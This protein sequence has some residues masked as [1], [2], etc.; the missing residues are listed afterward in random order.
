M[1]ILV[2]VIASAF[3]LSGCE[4]LMD[5]GAVG[6]GA[7]AVGGADVAA[8]GFEGADGAAA[9][10]FEG[11]EGVAAAEAGETEI[12]V[13]HD[14]FEMARDH[15]VISRALQQVTRNGTRAGSMTMTRSG[16]LRA[17]GRAIGKIDP[18]TGDIVGPRGVPAGYISNSQIFEFV[19]NGQSQAVA[20]LRGF[21][22]RNGVRLSPR[23]G[24]GTEV[25]ILH[26]RV[27]LDVLK[28]EP[29][30]YLVRLQDGTVGYIPSEAAH[31]F[32]LGLAQY[33]QNCQR[34]RS[35]AIVERSG[36]TVPF[37]DCSVQDGRFVIETTDGP[38]M[39]DASDVSGVLVGGSSE[40]TRSEMTSVAPTAD[41]FGMFE[42]AVLATQDPVVW[43]NYRPR[44]TPANL[45]FVRRQLPGMRIN[46]A[47]A[48]AFDARTR[49]R[50]GARRNF[51]M[52]ARPNF[53]L[54]TPRMN[55]PDNFGSR[56]G[57]MYGNN[58]HARA[59]AFTETVLSSSIKLARE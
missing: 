3:L 4:L 48:R 22:V 8:A 41:G 24:G 36:M 53:G 58:W 18:A 54:R 56:W 32:I 21:T 42:T 43:V 46:V 14:T 25:R 2:L 33:A 29:G 10:G 59:T 40:K 44:Y 52:R 55:R 31:L 5:A 20:E 17:D 7:A 28:L 34:D 27:Y 57:Q 11:T 51:G 13:S 15:G 6:E 39:I 35:G 1:R 50:F 12:A 16:F 47:R 9:V 30:R 45:E 49:A 19:R 37:I 26:S 23:L 38:R